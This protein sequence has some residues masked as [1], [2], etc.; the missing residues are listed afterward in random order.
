[1]CTS[2]GDR[3][4]QEDAH[5]DAWEA[6]TCE[7]SVVQMALFPAPGTPQKTSRQQSAS[8]FCIPGGVT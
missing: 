5:S 2:D 4:L 7:S 3:A 8:L 1:M 6:T